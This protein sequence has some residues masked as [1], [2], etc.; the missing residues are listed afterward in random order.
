[1]AIDIPPQAHELLTAQN[2][3][4]LLVALA[5]IKILHELG[6]ALGLEHSSN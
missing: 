4:W 1:M 6:H 3:A 5:V 2:L